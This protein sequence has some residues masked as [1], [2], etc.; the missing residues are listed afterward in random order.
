MAQIITPE[1]IIS[2]PKLFTPEA[3]SDDANA[4][5]KY[6]AA[7]IFPEGSDLTELKQ[8]AATAA[9]EKWG[10]KAAAM[11]SS[12][13]LRTPFRT[14][15][16]AK[17]YPEGSTFFNARSLQRPG[18]VSIY[19]DPNNDGKPTVI[20]DES[21]VVAGA[22]VKAAV[23]AFAYDVSGNKGISFGLNSVQL[24]R[25]P[26]AEERLDGRVAAQ[27]TFE[28]DQDAVADLSDL[29]TDSTETDTDADGDLSDLM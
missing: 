5:K 2:Y 9:Q 26:T 22:R 17:G 16:D 11:F 13:A 25:E 19:P 20:T 12:G 3:M 27:D 18:V 8:A 29:E 10:D 28:A 14:D 7:L 6:S 23:V 21:A 24:L 1:A 4:V 15:V